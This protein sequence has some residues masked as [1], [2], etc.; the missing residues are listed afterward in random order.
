MNTLFVLSLI[1]GFVV[2]SQSLPSHN[3]QH[4]QLQYSLFQ[5]TN[6]DISKSCSI[7]KTAVSFLHGFGSVTL[8][9]DKL[10]EFADF[11]CDKFEL[12]SPPVCHAMIPQ[13]KHI[14]WKIFFDTVVEPD[15]I[16]GWLIGNSCAETSSYFASWN[17]TLAAK[18]MDV[19]DDDEFG[20]ETYQVTANP[21]R[22]IQL[23]DTHIDQDYVEG[24]LA[25]CDEPLCCRKH[26]GKA[27]DKT[28]APKFGYSGHCDTNVLMFHNMLE[29]IAE[30]HKDVK[31]IYWTGDIPAHN[32][33]NQSKENQIDAITYA[34]VT[35]KKYFPEKK[36]F[37]TLGNHEGYPVDSF[38]PPSITGEDSDVWLRSTLAEK[39]GTWLPKDTQETIMR[40][41]F[42]TTM[43]E[44]N[45]RL[46]SLNMNYGN[47]SNFW[48]WVK[49]ED[50]AGQ[51]QWFADTLAKAEEA[52]EKVHVIGH[53]PPCQCLKWFSYNYYRI[54]NRFYKTIT[55]QFFGHTHNDEFRIFFDMETYT[56]PISIA[57]IAPSV[58][59]Y[60]D[61]NP[62]YIIYSIDGQQGNK[63]WNVIDHD[64]HYADLMEANKMNQLQFQHEYNTRKAYKMETLSPSS[65]NKL[66]HRFVEDD[67]SFQ[68]FYKSF[69][70]QHKKGYCTGKCKQ[71]YLCT[72]ASGMAHG[73]HDFCK[74]DNVE[75]T[76][77]HLTWRAE[78]YNKC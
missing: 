62:G 31:Y 4:K 32:V 10:V 56:K 37:P 41:G 77:T 21:V 7:C 2:I 61:L 46:I 53:I 66:L 38:P 45:L 23:T 36:I 16:C 17:V 57:Y 43:V 1:F 65:W 42:Y 74:F 29:G 51:L 55:G 40:G 58:T 59:T 25:D 11:I 28:T 18:R 15:Q 9:E 24:S 20:E 75:E 5:S 8:G 26:D 33:W 72:L 6:N 78:T 67:E 27:T 69:F 47:P 48:L 34:T 39:W 54:I 60:H 13:F 35:F 50:P 73:F 76:T 68:L 30:N 22:V 44:G 49:S 14:V 70:K 63:T 64:T 12:A 52:G 71:D 19:E 3:I